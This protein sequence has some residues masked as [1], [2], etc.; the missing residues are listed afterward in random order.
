MNHSVSKLN[1]MRF[2]ERYKQTDPVDLDERMIP[3]LERFNKIPGVVSFFL[4]FR[5]FSYRTRF[6]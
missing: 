2:V 1:Y 6:R 5:T 3:I 4:L